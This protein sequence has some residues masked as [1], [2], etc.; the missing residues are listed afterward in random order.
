MH[1]SKIL[2]KCIR[3]LYC[4]ESGALCQRI[5]RCVCVCVVLVCYCL[6]VCMANGSLSRMI[7]VAQ[8]F[9]S[10]VCC[11]LLCIKDRKWG[12][13]RIRAPIHTS[14]KEETVRVYYWLKHSCSFVWLKVFSC[15]FFPPIC[16]YLVSC[17]FPHLETTEH[18]NG[19]PTDPVTWT[20]KTLFF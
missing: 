12:Q 16:S 8:P 20:A 9:L 17:Q 1:I 15:I 4:V 3:S 7:P 19:T 14:P 2:N 18:F 5:S 11:S 10:A 6:W 13:R